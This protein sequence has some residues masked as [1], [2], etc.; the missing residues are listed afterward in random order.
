LSR[1]WS[2][3]AQT[4]DRIRPPLKPAGEDLQAI[5]RQLAC[6]ETSPGHRT[7][8]ILG[9][10][11]EYLSLLWPVDTSIFALDYS[12]VMFKTVWQ[13]AP[14]TGILGDWRRMPIMDQSQ[15]LVLLDAG[16]CLL[17][18]PAGQQQVVREVSRVLGPGGLFII[19]VLVMPAEPESISAVIQAVSDGDIPDL[20][21]LRIRLWMAMQHESG[22][23]ATNRQFWYKLQEVFRDA[24]N[25]P[26]AVTPARSSSPRSPARPC[27]N[28]KGIMNLPVWKIMRPCLRHQGPG[29]SYLKKSRLR[30]DWADV[31]RLLS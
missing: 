21:H 29:W 17:P 22:K 16:L 26:G 23:P 3:T 13:G 30:T 18:W 9:V 2:Y 11:R 31:V 20:S 10:T 28:R 24:K 4:W 7:V 15:Q 12:H 25:L 6:L 14:G 5:T 19:R 1:Q 8:L 27:S